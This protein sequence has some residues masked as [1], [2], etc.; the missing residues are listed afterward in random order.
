MYDMQNYELIDRKRYDTKSCIKKNEKKQTT[1]IRCRV[2]E[3]VY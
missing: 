1:Q 2:S 3:H